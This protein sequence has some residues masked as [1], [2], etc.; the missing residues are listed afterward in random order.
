MTTKEEE[1]ENA[2]IKEAL[3]KSYNF[4]PS[5][6]L[7]PEG[8]LAKNLEKYEVRKQQI[9]LAE[10]IQIA[11]EEHKHLVA[12]AA[13]GTGKSFAFLLA[14]IEKSIGTGTPVVISTH[15]IALQEQLFNKDIPFLVKHLQIPVQAV[16]AKGRSNYVSIRRAGVAKKILD[17]FSHEVQ[18]QHSKLEDWLDH[19]TD[20]TLASLPFKPSPLL[21]NRVKSDTDQCLGERCPTFQQCHY[22]SARKRLAEAQII[23]TNHT[24]VLLDLQMKSKGLN[25]VLPAFQYLVLDEAHELEG[26]A[27]QALTF[28]MNQYSIPD[29][30]TE[31]YNDKASGFLNV[32]YEKY[33][34]AEIDI[35]DAI[36]DAAPG[37]SG[38][39]KAPAAAPEASE[40]SSA[41]PTREVVLTT[42]KTVKGLLDQNL[43]FFDDVKTF[44]GTQKL[45]RFKEPNQIKTPLVDLLK[46]LLGSLKGLTSVVTHKNDKLAI[47]FIRKRSTEVLEGLESILTLP[48]FQDPK[49]PISYPEIVAWAT[50]SGSEARRTISVI[51]SPTFV[52]P[53]LRKILFSRISSVIMTSA[54]LATGGRD[55]FMMFKTTLGLRDPMECKLPPVFDYQKQTK[56]YLVTDAPEQK[57]PSYIP[58]LCKQV[59]KYVNLTRGG[60]FVLFTSFK[61]MTEV[62]KETQGLFEMQGYK[63]FC[64][65]ADLQRNQ[66]I[67]GFK[68]TKNGVLYGVDSFWTGVDIPGDSLRNVIITKLPFPPPDDPLAEVHTEIFKKYGRNYFMDRALPFTAIK[69][70]QGF[71]RLIRRADDRGIV[72]ILDSRVYTQRYG[73]FILDSLP[74][75]PVEAVS[76]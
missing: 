32:L 15:T 4:K 56:L 65:G 46:D 20:G 34:H 27:R 38:T 26:V 24:M 66:M 76:C 64:Q 47:E 72:V 55:P 2:S 9:H 43:T 63:T 28:E 48:M 29:M 73:K 61:T 6:I 41:V 70:K 7:G 69:L 39:R 21:W 23:V 67:D 19:T 31:L 17:K 54:T 75:C 18:S 25:G 74:K 16:L 45:V 1:Q 60:A 10:Q 50:N 42:V 58:Q 22:Q 33:S 62:Y 71:G 49:K 53:V 5:Y 37:L 35:S 44:L 51:A 57:D 8:P 11:F 30:L 3:A 13:T 12:E 14:A 59:I 40:E 68:N 36:A 52:N